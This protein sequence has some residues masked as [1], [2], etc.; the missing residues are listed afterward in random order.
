MARWHL[1]NIGGWIKKGL[2]VLNIN[3]KVRRRFTSRL[4]SCG[5]KTMVAVQFVFYSV[6]TQRDHVCQS[7][8][9]LYSYLVKSKSYFDFIE[10]KLLHLVSCISPSRY[11]CKCPIRCSIT[12][13]HTHSLIHLFFSYVNRL[14]SFFS[15][16]KIRKVLGLEWSLRLRSNRQFSFPTLFSPF[17]ISL[18][19][20][21][22]LL[23]GFFS[24]L[25]KSAS[26]FSP[27]FI[28][29][30]PLLHSLVFTN[31]FQCTSQPLSPPPSS[32]PPHHLTSFFLSV[33]W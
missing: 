21:W 9:H 24:F 23:S 11:N 32:L 14:F 8:R 25:S 20:Q 4:S 13:T 17:L 1:D 29:S 18:F 30:I 7:I 12:E 27:P 5:C 16:M 3:R 6:F 31:L 26:P 10:S 19:F 22:F 15:P 2:A 28:P 33:L